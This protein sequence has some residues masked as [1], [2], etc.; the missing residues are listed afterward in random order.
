[1]ER[2]TEDFCCDNQTLPPPVG[3][4][5][6]LKN[7]M[8]RSFFPPFFVEWQLQPAWSHSSHNKLEYIYSCSLI[9]LLAVC[10]NAQ[11]DQNI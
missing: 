9:H 11:Y 10:M 8:A 2:F 1:M 5:E 7:S 4:R 3:L 6:N